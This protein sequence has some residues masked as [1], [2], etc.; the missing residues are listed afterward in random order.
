MDIYSIVAYGFP[1]FFL[2]F[3]LSLVFYREHQIMNEPIPR[4]YEYLTSLIRLESDVSCSDDKL[5]S[6]LLNLSI[7]YSPKNNL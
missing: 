4:N 3:T 2:A 6:N 5:F 7:K 1:V